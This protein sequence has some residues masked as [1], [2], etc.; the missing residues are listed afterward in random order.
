[1]GREQYVSLDALEEMASGYLEAAQFTTDPSPGSG[2]YQPDVYNVPEATWRQAR[3]DVS[4]FLAECVKIDAM[5]PSWLDGSLDGVDAYLDSQESL[6]AIGRDIWYT[7]QGHGVG[8][9]D[10]RTHVDTEA[11]PY[12][13][14]VFDKAARNLPERY[15][16][17]GD[18]DPDGFLAAV[19]FELRGLDDVVSGA[20]VDGCD[21]CADRGSTED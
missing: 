2:E 17:W 13:L 12:A 4:R 5:A 1:M 15:W 8:F 3:A 19:G 20:Y 18:L 11:T 16:E 14:D 21:T 6:Q 10:R 9:W 7:S